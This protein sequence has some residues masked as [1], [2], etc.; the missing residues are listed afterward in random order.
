MEILM[1]YKTKLSAI[2]SFFILTSNVFAQEI[3][4]LPEDPSLV[5][6]TLPSGIEYYLLEDAGLKGFADIALV[7]KGR[8]DMRSARSDM[9]EI[10]G[11][12][13][14]KGVGYGD[15]GYLYKKGNA[16]LFSFN[17][18]PV[19]DKVT[20]DST[21][22]L[23]TGIMRSYS[24][25][26]A[27]MVSG[28]IDT[29]ELSEQLYMYSLMVPRVKDIIQTEEYSWEE[30]DKA[31]VT[32][33]Q[34]CSDKVNVSLNYRSPRPK[35][36]LMN[37]VQPLVSYKYAR[38][39]GIILSNRI[40]DAFEAEHIA[41]DEL[42]ARYRDASSTDGDESFT[43]SFN[44]SEEDFDRAFDLFAATIAGL[45]IQGATAPEFESAV[46]ARMPRRRGIERLV[47]AY[48]YGSSL[49]SEDEI[50]DFLGR[51]TMTAFEE[52]PLF[53]GYL[54]AVLDPCRNMELEV[55]SA[56]KLDASALADR[57][58]SAW[59]HPDFSSAKS[60]LN[61]ASVLKP[62]KEPW[63]VKKKSVLKDPVTSGE[64][65]TFSNGVKVIYKQV[66]GSGRFDYTLLLRGGFN[67][68]EAGDA[69]RLFNVAGLDPY[70]LRDLLRYEDITSD[71]S[72]G[73]S[74][75]RIYGDA[76]SGSLGIVL[77]LLTAYCYRRSISPQ[78]R[79]KSDR[80]EEINR[81]ITS[82]FA[83]IGDGALI[84]IGDLDPVTAED[85]LVRKL[86]IFT[87]N[88]QI[89]NRPVKSQRPSPR[90][91]T[92]T[93]NHRGRASGVRM[94]VSAPC[95]FS[96]DNYIAF[97]LAGIALQGHLASSLVEYGIT[98]TVSADFSIT[99]SE[100]ISVRIS[101]KP[102]DPDGL[103]DGVQPL[104]S[105]KILSLLRRIVFGLDD[106][107]ITPEMLEW[108]KA[109]LIERRKGYLST[110]EGL[111]RYAIFRNSAGKDLVSGYDKALG[112]I[113]ADDVERMFRMFSDG[114][115]EE[116][117]I[118]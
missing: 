93:E 5:R 32:V 88:K 33:L 43:I 58:S 44:T 55:C 82:Q 94:T 40:R 54:S 21:F 49:A 35:K 115:K 20:A 118:K 61:D 98:S 25:P 76:S 62:V 69:T 107:E 60:S 116:I 99:P 56:C 36:E 104:A 114:D 37:T 113:T 29:K 71:I 42:Q 28:D 57:F 89:S 12:M 48:L 7:Q 41:Q 78:A 92:R 6:G 83:K 8:Q 75:M 70:S 105:E 72:I 106:V 96:L 14:R 103:P 81:Y 3:P 66:P 10:S 111:M 18:V 22:V 86:G 13:S 47:S 97:Q 80:C 46:V 74:D 79:E 73:A 19:F 53:N 34:D 90:W 31:V 109:S 2:F 108:C 100:M 24:G 63:K 91:L 1:R 9:K 16:A 95:P 4:A 27:L 15:K 112:S 30:S 117:I 52:L 45:D 84:L 110:S 26:Q 38:K 39:T 59:G 68:P 51:R 101:M 67:A 85:I 87:T 64:I 11:F 50:N 77:D 102:C 23:L 65:W 17:S